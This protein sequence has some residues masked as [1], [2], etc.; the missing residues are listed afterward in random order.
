LFE[1][2]S[3]DVTSAPSAI[4]NAAA[5][6]APVMQTLVIKTASAEVSLAIKVASLNVRE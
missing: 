2:G 5:A 1:C 6:A 3:I 4:V